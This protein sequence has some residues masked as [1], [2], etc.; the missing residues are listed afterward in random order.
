[1]SITGFGPV[2]IKQE[3][4]EITAADRKQMGWPGHPLVVDI[5]KER[6]MLREGWYTADDLQDVLM[7]LATAIRVIKRPPE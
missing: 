2:P 1:M 6:V 4:A 7:D 5:L 3:G